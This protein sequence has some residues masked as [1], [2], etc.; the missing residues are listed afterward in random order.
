M[1]HQALDACITEHWLDLQDALGM[2]TDDAIAWCQDPDMSAVDDQTEVDARETVCR[3]YGWLHGAADVLDLT[4]AE[5]VLDA[6][7]AGR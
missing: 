7:G 1:R 3:E 6:L 5:M 2:T 4:V